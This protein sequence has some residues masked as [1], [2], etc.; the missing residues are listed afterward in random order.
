MNDSDQNSI[1]NLYSK[2]SGQVEK[3]LNLH[4]RQIFLGMIAMQYS[5]K[6]DVIKLVEKLEK[7]CIR[8]IHFSSENEQI[9]RVKLNTSHINFIIFIL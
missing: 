7:S 4:S 1:E 9:S 5:A 3:V 8:F 6:S 2:E